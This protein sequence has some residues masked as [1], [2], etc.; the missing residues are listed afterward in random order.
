[1]NLFYFLTIFQP[2]FINLLMSHDSFLNI[3]YHS[4][5]ANVNFPNHAWNMFATISLPMKIFPL[6]LSLLWLKTSLSYRM[7]FLFYS[8]LVCATFIIDIILGLKPISNRS[9]SCKD[10]IIVETFF[11]I[12]WTLLLIQLFNDCKH[13]PVHFHLS[14]RYDTSKPTFFKIDWP[15]FEMGYIL[16]QPD[17]CSVSLVAVKYLSNTS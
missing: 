9:N 14:L 2:P 10:I 4:S 15:F 1:M 13:Y 8:S 3:D 11:I 6:R 17:N 16:V 12:E 7:V 5:W